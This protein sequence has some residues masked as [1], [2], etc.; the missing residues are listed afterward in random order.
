VAADLGRP[1]T[2]APDDRCVCPRARQVPGRLRAGERRSGHGQ[3]RPRRGVRSGAGQQGQPP[4]PERRLD[5]LRLRAVERHDPAAAIPV[6]LFY[7][8]LIEE[9]LRDSNP[10]GRGK[11]TPGRKFGGHERGLV[12]RL[13]KLPW[14]PDERQWAAVLETAADEPA[15]NRVMLALAYDAAL[16]P[17][18]LCLLGTEDIDPGRRTLRVKA[19]NTKNCM[20]RPARDLASLIGVGNQE[21]RRRHPV[22]I[23]SNARPYLTAYAYL[24]GGFTAFDTIGR[25]HRESLAWRIFGRELVDDAVRQILDVAAVARSGG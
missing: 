21:L 25:F 13:V 7:D 19:E 5:R 16:R 18:E 10:V 23:G 17:E 1:G 12:P 3:S 9:G 20:E 11:Y 2:R 24:A 22:Q 8:H 4:R 15:R 6:R 14:I